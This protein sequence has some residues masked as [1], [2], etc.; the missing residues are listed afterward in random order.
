M[1]CK[2]LSYHYL[3]FWF[4]GANNNE[5]GV[6]FAKCQTWKMC[7]FYFSDEI[8][9]KFS[10]DINQQKMFEWVYHCGHNFMVSVA[11]T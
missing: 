3:W 9:L 10:P 6:D 11:V 2:V 8:H 5:S 1:I 4:Y 7:N